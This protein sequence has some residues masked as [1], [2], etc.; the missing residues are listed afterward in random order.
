MHVCSMGHGG[1]SRQGMSAA[2]GYRAG[3][4]NAGDVKAHE[5]HEEDAHDKEHKIKVLS[6]PP[7]PS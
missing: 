2:A 5:G 4:A 7:W 6:I 3:I 1:A